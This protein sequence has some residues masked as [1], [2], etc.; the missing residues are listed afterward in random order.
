M[1]GMRVDDAARLGTGAVDALVQHQGLGRLGARNPL[2]VQI[3][4]GQFGGI[5]P[6]QAGVGGS[7][8]PAVVQPGADVAGGAHGVAAVVEAGA[9]DA[10]FFANAGFFSHGTPLARRG[11]TAGEP[12]GKSTSQPA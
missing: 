11:G 9:D 6:A 2:A 10:D 1:R 8:Q 4:L 12:A 5:Q 7:D 3:D